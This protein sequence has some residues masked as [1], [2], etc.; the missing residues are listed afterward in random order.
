MTTAITHA[1]GPTQANVTITALGYRVDALP[2]TNP[3]AQHHRVIIRPRCGGY[4]VM[5]F[6]NS[7]RDQ[8]AN[9]I[10]GE[11]DEARG[12]WE[13]DNPD[14]PAGEWDRLHVFGWDEAV[15]LAKTYVVGKLTGSR[16]PHERETAPLLEVS[17]VVCADSPISAAKI[18]EALS[19]ARQQLAGGK[20]GFQALSTLVKTLE[21]MART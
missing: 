3:N 13:Y 14:A 11:W 4:V 9:K 19:V 6:E 5:Q 17:P 12:Y 21:G 15:A 7:N 8:F 20:T 16:F 2:D 1:N 18:H 10:T